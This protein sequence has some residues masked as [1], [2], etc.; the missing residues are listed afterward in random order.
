MVRAKSLEQLN[1]YYSPLRSPLKKIG[2]ERVGAYY[3]PNNV[4]PRDFTI[5]Q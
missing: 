1:P 2:I 3:N 4:D 5:D